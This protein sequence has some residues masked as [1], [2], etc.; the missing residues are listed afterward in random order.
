MTQDSLPSHILI[1]F[2]C[3]WLYLPSAGNV[4]YRNSFFRQYLFRSQYVSRCLQPCF[5]ILIPILRSSSSLFP[6]K[7]HW[8]ET[9]TSTNMHK[10]RAMNLRSLDF[11]YTVVGCKRWVASANRTNKNETRFPK[12]HWLSQARAWNGP[13]K[14]APKGSNGLR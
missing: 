11:L 4:S 5:F 12:S 6:I 14:S 3:K 9:I 13:T 2:P 8:N 7:I 10:W 1:L